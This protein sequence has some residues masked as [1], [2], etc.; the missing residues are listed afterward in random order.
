[1]S[2]VFDSWLGF[3]DPQ[4]YDTLEGWDVGLRTQVQ[5]LGLRLL[6]EYINHGQF[7]IIVVGLLLVWE[8]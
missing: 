8:V 6:L 3:E 4:N 1:M 5:D 7:A 2:Y